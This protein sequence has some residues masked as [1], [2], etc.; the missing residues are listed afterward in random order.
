IQIDHKP[1]S[2]AASGDG[3]GVKVKD[4]CRCGDY[5]YRIGG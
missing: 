2:K 3:V 4:K 1:V 5:V